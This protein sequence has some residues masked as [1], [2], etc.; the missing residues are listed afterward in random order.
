[1][2]R[3]QRQRQ[4]VVVGLK[5]VGSPGQWMGFMV[6]EGETVAILSGASSD[7]QGAE[8]RAHH[9]V[10]KLG[11]EVERFAVWVAEGSRGEWR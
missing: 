11:L 7:K 9:Q 8:L 4:R 3:R 5:L 10:E 1:M 2:L 6:V